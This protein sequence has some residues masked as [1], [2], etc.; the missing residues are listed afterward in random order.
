MPMAV[1]IIN[2]VIEHMNRAIPA[3]LVDL[4]LLL[5]K[6]DHEIYKS[7]DKVAGLIVIIINPGISLNHSLN[8]PNLIVIKI[9]I[10]VTTSENIMVPAPILIPCLPENQ[11]PA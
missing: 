1:N 11:I 7:A 10:I 2:P 6:T 3:I 4:V 9:I 5:I 8:Q